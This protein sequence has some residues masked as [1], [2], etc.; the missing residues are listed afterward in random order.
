MSAA[1][2]I[3]VVVLAVAA[4]AL[5]S[6]RFSAAPTNRVGES[7]GATLIRSGGSQ[8]L[9][10]GAALAVGDE[11]RVAADGHATLDL[12]SS[13][14]RLAGGADIRLNVLSGSAVQLALLAGRAYHRVVLPVG[15]SYAVVTGPYT[16]T[17]TGTAFDLDRT[18]ASAGGEQVTLLA[19]EHALAI[20]GPDTHRQIAEGSSVAVLFGNSASAGVTVGPI[21]TSVFSDPWLINNA[22]TDESLGY[23]IGALAGVAL[24]PNDTPS[25]SPSLSLAPSAGASDSP[26][27]SPSPSVAPSHSPSPTPGVTPGPR[28]TPTATA[29]PTPTVK[30]V[31][32]SFGLA[33]TSCPGGVVLNW[34]KYSG[35][36]FARYV[37]L[38]SSTTNNIPKAY[39]PAAGVTAMAGT[40][41]RTKTSGADGSVVDGKTYFYRT[42]ALGPAGKV[43]AASAVESA[44]GFGQVDLGF[45][46]G[47]G[48]VS[49]AYF[50][51]PAACFSEYRL[52]YSTDPNPSLGNSTPE[53][54]T[55]WSQSSVGI[56]PSASW[57][58][59][60]TIYFLVQV[61]RTTTVGTFVV[62]QTSN[63]QSFVYP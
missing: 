8:A 23:P 21:P 44:P 15:G 10:A 35:T 26:S 22:K 58:H 38:R 39:P 56:P 62:G 16:W 63:I 52:L 30:P 2:G 53:A 5:L 47:Q 9:A 19:L 20:D 24:A 61:V 31:P 60:Q 54:I 40:T 28:A 49:W 41:V 12:G 6:G 59:G 42:L 48:V 25:T 55:P 7:A 17:A 43:L 14:T 46:F 11:I 4:A 18:P 57:K 1:L 32:P 29:S 3:G 37:T 36:G 33:L 50:P 51:G 45:S 13:Q 27:D 34:S